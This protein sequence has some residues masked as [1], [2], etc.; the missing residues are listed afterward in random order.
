MSVYIPPPDYDTVRFTPSQRRQERPAH[1]YVPNYN[2]RRPL[3][4]R[5]RYQEEDKYQMSNDDDYRRRMQMIQ[6]MGVPVLPSLMNR[7]AMFEPRVEGHNNKAF[8]HHVHNH[9][10]YDTLHSL[11]T[12]R[13]CPLC[14][15][16]KNDAVA[17]SMLES[18]DK[19]LDEYIEEDLASQRGPKQHEI[20]SEQI[21]HQHTSPIITGSVFRPPTVEEL[22][23][24]NE[25]TVHN[26]SH[27]GSF[28]QNSMG[29]S[30]SEKKGDSLTS[31]EGSFIARA[32]KDW[33]ADRS[34]DLSV[35]IGELLTVVEMRSDWWLCVNEAGERGWLPEKV[36]YRM[37]SSRK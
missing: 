17:Q 33:L 6:N 13:Q 2:Y 14:D 28:T 21:Q 3:P 8:L 7:R 4:E 16:I 11:R 31:L 35:T 5:P 20:T 22:R 15:S 25:Y 10:K 1:H 27:S 9:R 29:P 19:D 32:K 34:T 26:S 37:G 18:M 36:L 30:T 23:E 24:E 12:T